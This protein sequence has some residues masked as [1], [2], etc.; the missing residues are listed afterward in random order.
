[1]NTFGLEK[2]LI[3][4]ST[5]DIFVSKRTFFCCICKVSRHIGS[6][7]NSAISRDR[8]A[9]KELTPS[10]KLNSDSQVCII[11][12]NIIFKEFPICAKNPTIKSFGITCAVV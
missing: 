11:I 2:I 6:A 10:W 5:S 4:S 12:I 7:C 8:S 1:M 9:R 3:A